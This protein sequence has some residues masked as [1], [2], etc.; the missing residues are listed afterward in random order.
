M[1]DARLK[2]VS[3]QVDH[4]NQWFDRERSEY[5]QV[6]RGR[7]STSSSSAMA[8]ARTGAPG[9]TRVG[10]GLRVVEQARHHA[11]HVQPHLKTGADLGWLAGAGTK[12]EV[13][14]RS[15]STTPTPGSHPRGY[16]QRDSQSP[17]P[18]SP[19][20]ERPGTADSTPTFADH[21]DGRW[22]ASVTPPPLTPNTR[23]T[24]GALS[25]HQCT[26]SYLVHCPCLRESHR[27]RARAV[28]CA[29]THSA[30]RARSARGTWT[31][32]SPLSGHRTTSSVRPT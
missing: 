26:G 10:C 18:P 17:I 14:A 4:F 31:G 23:L 15:K 29:Q 7:P 19:T 30:R 1:A 28:A 27:I 11:G 16:P 32:G 2:N 25:D 6:Q 3:N 22:I 21:K 8:R 12:S 24:L 13:V 9:Q 5:E 20:N